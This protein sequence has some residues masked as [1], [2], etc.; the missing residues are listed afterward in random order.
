MRVFGAGGAADRQP[1]D[2][3]ARVG[4]RIGVVGRNGGVVGEFATEPRY[5]G[6][7]SSQVTPTRVDSFL[8]ELT[9]HVVP[10][11]TT[12]QIDDIVHR[13]TLD[14]GGWTVAFVGR[15]R[16]GIAPLGCGAG[17]GS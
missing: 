1:A 17:G 8:D 14:G 12:Q 16:L 4:D 5:Q 3:A 13:M 7:G 6:A 2:L 10:G 11:V 15:P 9:K